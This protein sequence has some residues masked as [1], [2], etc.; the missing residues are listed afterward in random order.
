MQPHSCAS[1]TIGVVVVVFR[2]SPTPHTD[3]SAISALPSI[4][5]TNQPSC[6]IKHF[7]EKLIQYSSSVGSAR[8]DAEVARL[9]R[10]V[11]LRTEKSIARC[12]SPLGPKRIIDGDR[13]RP[14]P[15]AAA[16]SALQGK[17]YTTELQCAIECLNN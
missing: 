14:T 15:S 5:P 7:G 8:I 6:V 3:H 11:Q 2:H 16:H 12:H 4:Q 9:L 10:S 1:T 13:S 17:T